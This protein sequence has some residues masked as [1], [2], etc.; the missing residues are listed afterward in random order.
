MFDFGSIQIF[1]DFLDEFSCDFFYDGNPR[2]L[3][4][5]SALRIGGRMITKG[6]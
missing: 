5:D 4:E 1:G 6:E 3:Y 2:S